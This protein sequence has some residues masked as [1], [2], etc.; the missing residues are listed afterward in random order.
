MTP[1]M[2]AEILCD[3]LDLNPLT[4]V[5]A[6]ASAIRQQIESYPTDSILDEQ[7]DQR[8]IIKVGHV[9]STHG[10]KEG[11]RE[12]Y[13]VIKFLSL[14]LESF[15]FCN[16]ECTV[17]DIVCIASWT[18]M[19]ETFPWWTSLSGT[20]L[21]RRTLQKRLRWSC[22]LSSA[23]EESSSPPSPTASAASSAGIRGR[24]PSGE[25]HRYSR[26]HHLVLMQEKS[27]N[28]TRHWGLYHEASPGQVFLNILNAMIT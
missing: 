26:T 13:I 11:Y 15:L 19:W 4:F 20:C 8:V 23:S 25:R 28:E 10:W 12:M 24:T 2:F 5:P 14:K 9:Y 3:D 17:C 6:I 7:T 18:S 1:E 27:H 21:R 22:A 16:I